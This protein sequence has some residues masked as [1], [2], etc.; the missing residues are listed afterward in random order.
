MKIIFLDFESYYDKDYSLRKLTPPEYVLSPQFELH[1]C[2]GKEG[3]E[4]KPYWVPGYDFGDWLAKIDPK[5]TG[6]IT[7]NALFDASI[8]AWRYN[9][10]ATIKMREER[11][12]G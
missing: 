2:A 10:A 1:G 7:Y 12:S 6:I 8:L 9:C 4:G 11:Q 5:D 3:T